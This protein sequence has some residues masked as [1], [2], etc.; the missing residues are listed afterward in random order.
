MIDIVHLLGIFRGLGILSSFVGI[1]SLI[2]WITNLIF[3]KDVDRKYAPKAILGSI[4][5][6]LLG[7]ILSGFALLKFILLNPLSIVL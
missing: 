7:E 4:G 1:F 3:N 2:A 5:L 6:T